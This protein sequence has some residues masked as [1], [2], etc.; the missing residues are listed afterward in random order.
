MK[1]REI[2]KQLQKL[3]SLLKNNEITSSG[4]LDLQ[5]HWSK[6]LCVLCAG[7]IENS[8]K[9]IC[10]EF[11]SKRSNTRIQSYCT[12]NLNKIQNPKSNRLV[13]IVQMFDKSWSAELDIFL[14]DNG[15]SDA[16]N[17]IMN[18]RH[19]IAHGKDVG[20]TIVRVSNYLDKT[21]EV[22]NFIENKFNP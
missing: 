20:L 8:I 5:A 7:L 1:N 13:E 10:V 14:K 15:R 9:E 2:A 22:I 4:D 17:S 19:Q 18:N 6:Y 12:F 11:C 3:Q 21:I 16:I